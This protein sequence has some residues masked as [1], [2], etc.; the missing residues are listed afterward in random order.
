MSLKIEIS[1]HHDARAFAALYRAQGRVQ[2]R[3]FLTAASADALEACLKE[4]VAYNTLFNKGDKVLFVTEQQMA[5]LSPEERTRVVRMAESQATEG[6][7]YFY[8]AHR[9]SDNGEAYTQPRD[10]LRAYSEFIRSPEF[11]VF[12]QTVT[13]APAIAYADAQATRYRRGSFLNHHTDDVSGTNRIAAYV[14]NL[15]QKWRPDW[16]GVLLFVDP[17][18]NVSEGY[19]PTYN[20]INLFRVPQGHMV[21]Q[22]SSYAGADRLSITGWLRSRATR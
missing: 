22:V 5:S 8:D 10:A 1:S 21:S 7:Q 15:T 4:D 9:V 6:F 14:L 17:D 20:A 11:L 3:E 2:I 16:G 12:V 13:D 18:G 19:T